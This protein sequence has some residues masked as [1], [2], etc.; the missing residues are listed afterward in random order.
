MALQ[1]LE[2]SAARAAGSMRCGTVCAVLLLM[3]AIGFAYSN[4]LNAIWTIDDY[5]NILQNPQLHLREFHPLT[6]FQ[7]FFSPLHRDADG[8][9]GLNRPLAH[10]SFA[11]NWYFGQDSPAGYRLVN[12]IIHLLNAAL[13]FTV[14][15][16]LLQTPNLHGRYAGREG[17]LALLAAGLWALNPVQTQAVVYIVQRMASLAC[18][19]YLLGI[20][21]YLKLRACRSHRRRIGYALLA[22]ASYFAAIGSKE[23]AVLLPAAV[24][25]LELSFYQD[26]SQPAVRRRFG[27]VVGISCSLVLIVCSL[28]LA[29]GKAAELLGYGIRLFSPGERLLSQP[30]IILFYMSQ[31]F[32]PIPGRLSLVHD[33]EISR[34]LAD[35]WTTLPSIFVVL[36]LIGIGFLQIRRR[37]LLSFA[38]LFFFLNHA[39]ES[40]IIGLELIYEHRN[41]LPSLFLF[42]PLAAALQGLVAREHLMSSWLRCLVILFMI[43]LPAGFGIG[44]Y[45]RNMAWLD[46]KTFWEDAARKAPLSMRPLH[47]LAYYHYEKNGRHQ[48]AFELYHQALGRPDSNRLILSLPHI[49][50]AEHYERRNDLDMAC[51]H[52]EHAL[53]IFPEFEQ[54]RFRLALARFTAGHYDK[55]I[56]AAAPLAEKHPRSFDSRYLTAQILLKMGQAAEAIGHLQTCMLLAPDSEKAVFMMG[57]A[58][59]LNG[60]FKQ[61]ESL[62]ERLRARFPND[63][64]TLLWMIDGR[65][66]AADAEAAEAYARQFLEGVPLDRIAQAIDESLTDGFMPAANR[67]RLSLWIVSQAHAGK[68]PRLEKEAAAA[69][70]NAGEPGAAR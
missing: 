60:N 5:P 49:K 3:A 68:G 32:Y 18:F 34:S 17:S 24:F 11:L 23:N 58:A 56:A 6:L 21:S 13:L 35:P 25:L 15:Q 33:V 4:S 22:A 8:N 2:T 27:W 44:T 20:W 28:L 51:A 57:I 30:R 39:V 47:N 59:N 19:F 9:P 37:P 63:K 48:E 61:A 65:L 1:K 45:V 16:G 42:V 70:A 14:I 36:G 52:L 69:S 41:Y 29:T 66:Q 53:A 46:A 55:A 62:M 10:L 67:E 38:I 40:G 50:I 64:Q 12:I 54:V 7:S 26:W 43:V 31:L